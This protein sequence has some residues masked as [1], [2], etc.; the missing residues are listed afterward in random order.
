MMCDWSVADNY[1][2]HQYQSLLN[3]YLSHVNIPYV[4]NL[5]N[6]SN[7]GAIIDEYYKSILSCIKTG[8]QGAIPTR[9]KT[10]SDKVVPGW[11]YFVT[12]KHKTA[13][14]AFLQ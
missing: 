6:V 11:K 5:D 12:E 7:A 2:L 9:V 10:W 13:R 8:S 4:A 1:S 3:D 14:D